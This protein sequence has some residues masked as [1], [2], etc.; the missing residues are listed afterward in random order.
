MT[1]TSKRTGKQRDALFAAREQAALDELQSF[2]PGVVVTLH[3]PREGDRAGCCTVRLTSTAGKQKLLTGVSAS[4]VLDQLRLHEREQERLSPDSPR[5][6]TIAK[7][8]VPVPVIQRRGS[9]NQ[10]RERRVEAARHAA[11]NTPAD[12]YTARGEV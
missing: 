8:P 1:I 2:G 7:E 10:S 12:A 9:E 6:W 4:H 3:E 5:V 11:A